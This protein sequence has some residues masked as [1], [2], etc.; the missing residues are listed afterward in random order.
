MDIYYGMTLW[1]IVTC[2]RK[3][4]RLEESEGSKG[5]HGCSS[6]VVKIYSSTRNYH[7]QARVFVMISAA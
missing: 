4:R 7:S 6:V 2:G 5:S 1:M 3:K